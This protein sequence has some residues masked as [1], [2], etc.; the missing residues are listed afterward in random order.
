MLKW[1]Y[2]NCERLRVK[3]V[4]KVNDKIVPFDFLIEHFFFH[5]VKLNI[6]TITRIGNIHY[7]IYNYKEIKRKMFL[8]TT[9]AQGNSIEVFM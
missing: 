1:S 5:P 7:F 6:C 2:T 9:S 3:I 8:K 4:N